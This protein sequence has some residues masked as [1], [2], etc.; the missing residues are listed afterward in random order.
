MDFNFAHPATKCSVIQKYCTSFYGCE[1][2]NLYSDEFNQSS[3]L[4]MYQFVKLGMFH[5]EHI[6]VLYKHCQVFLILKF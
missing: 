2:W 3:Q 4:G 6:G 1:L 5:I